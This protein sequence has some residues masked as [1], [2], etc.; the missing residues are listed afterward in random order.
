MG[1]GEEKSGLMDSKWTTIILI[2]VLVI[3][4][5]AVIYVFK[6]P[7]VLDKLKPSRRQKQEPLKPSIMNQQLHSPSVQ[8]KLESVDGRLRVVAELSWQESATPLQI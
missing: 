1:R 4:A 7:Q 8:S 3:L 5:A 2:A 6:N